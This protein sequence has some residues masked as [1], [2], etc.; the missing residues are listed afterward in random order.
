MKKS[1]L[2][3]MTQSEL[4]NRFY[5]SHKTKTEPRFETKANITKDWDRNGHKRTVKTAQSKEKTAKG[6]CRS[7]QI[8]RT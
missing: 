8:L 5:L 3:A 1:E 7:V 4:E 2:P 6:Y